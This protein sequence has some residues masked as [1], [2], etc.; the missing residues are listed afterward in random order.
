LS[1]P[2]FTDYVSARVA[3]CED[4]PGTGFRRLSMTAR[5][6]TKFAGYFA[7]HPRPRYSGGAAMP[8]YVDKTSHSG[9]SSI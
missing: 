9:T 7:A 8:V 5:G 4:R 6:E 2:N 3:G 1:K